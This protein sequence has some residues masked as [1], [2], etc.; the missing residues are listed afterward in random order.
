MFP[1]DEISTQ[2]GPESRASAAECPYRRPPTLAASGHRPERGSAAL[3]TYRDLAAKGLA[4]T[5]AGN[6]TA[7]LRGLRPVDQGWTVAEIDRLLFLRYLVDRDR[8]DS[9][10]ANAHPAPVSGLQGGSNKDT[11][12]G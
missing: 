2:S 5:E 4:P 12:R 1:N 10:N 9:L 6:L 3:A 7:Y 8:L 11:V